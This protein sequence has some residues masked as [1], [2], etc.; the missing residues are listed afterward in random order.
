MVHGV[1]CKGSEEAD[2]GSIFPE[3][4]HQFTVQF[5]LLVSLL[6]GEDPLSLS[7]WVIVPC[8]N[9]PQATVERVL[10]EGFPRCFSWAIGITRRHGATTDHRARQ[11]LS[12][13]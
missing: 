1:R 13:E 6:T 2:A 10:K 5:S 12:C 9:T 4:S 11:S 7:Q 8:N 3:G